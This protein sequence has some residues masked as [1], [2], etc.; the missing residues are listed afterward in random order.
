MN[1]QLK[2]KMVMKTIKLLK[3]QELTNCISIQKLLK[4]S[5]SEKSEK[6]NLCLK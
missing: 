5:S 4:E 2:Q 6:I 3:S 1:C